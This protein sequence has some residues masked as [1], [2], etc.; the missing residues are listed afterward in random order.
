MPNGPNEKEDEAVRRGAGRSRVSCRS[1]LEP[2]SET[3]KG[4]DRAILNLW[5]R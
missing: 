1:R 4:D 5:P 3:G 2:G